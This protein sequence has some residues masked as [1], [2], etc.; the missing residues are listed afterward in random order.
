M[1]RT[2]SKTS[3]NTKEM[4]PRNHK[5]AKEILYSDVPEYN[6]NVTHKLPNTKDMPHRDYNIQWS[7]PDVG[8]FKGN[9]TNKLQ[10]KKEMLPR[11]NQIQMNVTQ[12]QPNRK[13]MLPPNSKI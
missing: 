10:H 6:G 13:E 4:L 8:E 7:Y 3:N 2:V 5:H 12:M 11:Q 1:Q 9:A